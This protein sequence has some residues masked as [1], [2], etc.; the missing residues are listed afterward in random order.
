[1][2]EGDKVY[3]SINQNGGIEVRG[4]PNELND[5]EEELVKLGVTLV[6]AEPGKRYL[7]RKKEL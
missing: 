7:L 5:I 3:A 2:G 6:K 4:T 1:M